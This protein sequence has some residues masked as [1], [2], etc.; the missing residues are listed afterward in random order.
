MDLLNSDLETLENAMRL[1]FQTMKRPHTWARVT[2]QTG[3]HLDRPA[4]VILHLLADSST[5]LHVQD[6]ASQL[7]IE[8][9]SVTRKTQSLERAGYLQRVPDAR[10][11]RLIDLRITPRGRAA[12]RKLWGAQRNIVAETL[13]DWNS[14]ERRQFVRLFERFSS[15]LSKLSQRE[16]SHRR[17]SHA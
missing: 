5:P 1:F 13:K 11:R 4:A 17:L 15:D 14:D 6:L 9:P 7:G 16:P 2:E 3:I 8:A 12:A 10:D